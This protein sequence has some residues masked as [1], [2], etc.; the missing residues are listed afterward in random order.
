MVRR[1]TWSACVGV[2]LTPACLFGQ[3][4]KPLAEPPKAFYEDLRIERPEAHSFHGYPALDLARLEFSDLLRDGAYAELEERLRQLG[5]DVR[6]DVRWERHLSEAYRAFEITDAE[7]VA[8]LAAWA[9]TSPGSPAPLF[10]KARQQLATI[11]RLRDEG[12]LP[13]EPTGAY[14]GEERLLDSDDEAYAF[15]ESARDA[16]ARAAEI[17]P[18][19]YLG[20]LIA[21]E[22]EQQVGWTPRTMALLREATTHYPLSALLREQAAVNSLPQWGGTIDIVRR[23]AAD[24]APLASSNPRLSVL[25]GFEFLADARL[26]MVYLDLPAVL[27]AQSRALEAGETS[28]AYDE[29]GL[30]YARGYDY[31]RS[32][33][34]FNGALELRPWDDYALRRRATALYQIAFH[35]PSDVRSRL[36]NAA[37]SDYALAVRL[38]PGDSTRVRSSRN[39]HRIA[40]A[41]VEDSDTCLDAY[42]P[43][44]ASTFLD[45]RGRVLGVVGRLVSDLGTLFRSFGLRTGLPLLVMVAGTIALWRKS[46]FWLPRYVH[47]LALASLVPIVYIN[48][49]WVRSGGPMWTRRY[50]LIA[51]FPL[52]VYFIFLTYGGLRAALGRKAPELREA[53]GEDGKTILD[54]LLALV[55]RSSE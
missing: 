55:R 12:A 25:E 41:C 43:A 19:H 13:P 28:R 16:L 53:E 37:A 9:E 31:V 23:I 27:A 14:Q 40:A 51:A 17:E 35:V 21:L 18:T 44:T 38:D 49:L 46:G 3:D 39:F 36:L 54:V 22:V 8:A 29:R 34:D 7:G 15:L 42:E 1:S 52:S 10:A 20:Y 45:G 5:E 4:F 24:A 6:D 32:L 47:V 11:E 48:W 26:A 30:T 33:E 2:A 50:L